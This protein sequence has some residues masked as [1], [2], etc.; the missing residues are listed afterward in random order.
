MYSVGTPLKNV[1]L[2]RR[3]VA[4]QIL[5]VARIRHQ[6]QR[7]AAHECES[8]HADVRVDV[9]QRQRHEAHVVLGR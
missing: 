6:R 4:E 9:E 2:T 3:K 7:G 5:Q 8:L 1:G